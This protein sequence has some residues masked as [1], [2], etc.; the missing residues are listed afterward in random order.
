MPIGL[1]KKND[2]VF[3]LTLTE[4]AFMLIFLM[5]L[6][7]GW[8]VLEAEQKARDTAEKLAQSERRVQQVAAEKAAD[9]TAQS[10]LDAYKGRPYRAEDVIE[11]L[12]KCS[13]LE[14][15]N[16]GL[17]TQIAAL[18]GQAGTLVAFMEA[19]K[20]LAGR[21]DPRLAAQELATAMAFRNGFE[22]ASG[23]ALDGASATK[24]GW[25]CVA[26]MAKNDAMERDRQNLINQ[27]T[28][29]RHQLE[30]LNGSKG[31]G[32]PPCWVDNNGRVQRLLAVEVAENGLIVRPGWPAEREGEAK[33]LPNIKNLAG[34]GQALT[35]AAFRAAALP[36]LEWSRT[37]NPECR[38]Y[39]SITISATRVDT[40][41]AGQNAVAD[42]FFPYGK[43][44]LQ[45]GGR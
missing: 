16:S 13:A 23:Q 45:K 1:P 29:M 38:H 10:L 37:R 28:F 12:R 5:M 19:M 22:Q 9:K 34:G 30:S 14:P 43:V 2:Q 3:Q 25:E 8:M 11:D 35:I 36:V 6:I 4:L 33:Q 18:E 40:S 41:L 21:D 32:L 7:T 39:A 26:A 20:T 42:H 17:K 27:V 15:E 44:S 31:F 24:R